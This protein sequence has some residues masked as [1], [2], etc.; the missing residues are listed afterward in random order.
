MRGRCSHRP[1][2]S[3]VEPLRIPG[4]EKFISSHRLALALE[5][6]LFQEALQ[7]KYDTELETKSVVA[8]SICGLHTKGSG[9]LK[10]KFVSLI[11]KLT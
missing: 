5:L 4:S 2:S 10:I 1:H 9:P 6:A 7:S 3:L 8:V 11:A